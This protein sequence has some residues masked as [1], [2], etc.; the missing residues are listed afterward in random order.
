MQK[1]LQV[2]RIAIVVLLCIIGLLIA[3]NIIA[4]QDYPPRQFTTSLTLDVYERPCLTGNNCQ[5]IRQLA[6][7]ETVTIYGPYVASNNLIFGA[8]DA[9]LETWT[10]LARN[11]ICPVATFGAI[12]PTAL[13]IAVF[14]AETPIPDFEVGT[15]E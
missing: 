9:E 3:T 6:A 5:S 4:Q 2:Q 14:T 8:L 15:D 11:G 13:G 1:V 7:G 12:S 10:P